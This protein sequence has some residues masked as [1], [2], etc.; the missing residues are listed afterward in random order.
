MAIHLL[1]IHSDGSEEPVSWSDAVL[2]RL[3][4][5]Q[6][7][8][9]HVERLRQ[10]VAVRLFDRGLVVSDDDRPL[11]DD[12]ILSHLHRTGDGSPAR[13]RVGPPPAGARAERARPPDTRAFEDA[14]R[15]RAAVWAVYDH[16]NAAVDLLARVTESQGL[17][18][19]VWCMGRG[20][21]PPLP[22]GG[23]AEAGE[24][25]DAVAAN[26][27]LEAALRLEPEVPTV[28][29]FLDLPTLHQYLEVNA[30]AATLTQL[31]RRVGRDPRL[32]LVALRPEDEIPHRWRGLFRLVRLQTS[33]SG[34]PILDALAD[35]LTARARAGRLAPL[36]GRE[37]ELERLLDILNR[38]P[39]LPNS[40]LLVGPA[41][42]GKTALIEGVAALVAAGAAPPRF[43]GRRVMALNVTD[44]GAS[45][46][47]IGGLES[48]LRLLTMELEEHAANLIVFVDEIH[49]LLRIGGAGAPAAQA[50]K[51]SLGRGQIALVGATT[52]VEVAEVERDP[53]FSRRFSRII[54]AEPDLEATLA[55]ALRRRDELER[56]HGVSI[57]DDVVEAAV[58]EGDW[59]L[60]DLHRPY[61]AL[62]LLGDAAAAAQRRRGPTEVTTEDVY[63]ALRHQVGMDVRPPAAEEA[64]HLRRLEARLLEQ[65]VGQEEAVRDLMRQVR[66][67]RFRRDQ[68]RRPFTTLFVGPTGVGKTELATLL[69][70][71]LF[72]GGE[73]HVYH[74]EAFTQEHQASDLI[75]A[76]ASFVGFDQGSR[77]VNDI[78][79][80]PRSVLIFD[81]IEKAHPRVAQVLMGI[82]DR[83]EYVDPRGLRGDFR[84]AYFVFTSNVLSEADAA[85]L[86]RERFERCVRERFAVLGF[87]PEQVGRFG[88]PI[89]FRALAPAERTVVAERALA[90]L[91]EEHRAAYGVR[92][93]W[94]AGLPAALARLAGDPALGARPILRRIEDVRAAVVDALFLRPDLPTVL[95]LELGEDGELHARDN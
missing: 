59:H 11:L 23:A 48:T 16:A 7:P 4:E 86:P 47:H 85:D 18:P 46:E 3:L 28:L 13:V 25:P 17:R 29:A 95:R 58:T 73:P 44:L 53:A 56:F 79:G 62:T 64:A 69:G 32:R 49:A 76:P 27:A 65:I 87:A 33:R 92:I 70:A 12:A 10:W 83:G 41:G 22:D 82:V 71:A 72:P 34:T 68:L 19:H 77:L 21:E 81:E 40:P 74:M 8:E 80:R 88:R 66:G 30:F 67:R 45:A 24:G 26:A 93:T 54:L 6:A 61:S 94:A 78:R 42:V 43:Q 20:F 35:D 57:S 1:L 37:A 91:A 50:L 89:R 55:I 52:D 90:A 63:D 75:G 5:D 31:A 51:A 39:G 9:R 60:A 14:L 2:G 84:H 15:E 38:A 36:V